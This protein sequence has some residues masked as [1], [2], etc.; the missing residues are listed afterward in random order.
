MVWI[1]FEKCKD[2]RGGLPA[3]TF[4]PSGIES[5]DIEENHSSFQKGLPTDQTQ[6]SNSV[7]TNECSD[8]QSPSSSS[9][10]ADENGNSTLPASAIKQQTILK[11]RHSGYKEDHFK[12][13]VSAENQCLRFAHDDL[14][15]KRRLIDM[16]ERKEKESSDA[17][18]RVTST[19]EKLT[20]SVAAAFD[21]LNTSVLNPQHT[22]P[23]YP[24]YTRL[25]PCSS[26]YHFEH[27]QAM[28]NNTAVGNNGLP[29]GPFSYMHLPLQENI[30]I[31]DTHK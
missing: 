21:V 19:I 7:S 25:Q 29:R 5:A 28:Q 14:Q 11:R 18:E 10:I 27:M 2:I 1:Y 13:K 24:Q 4:I 20:S 16:M 22:Y 23:N 30:D 6:S 8:P 9:S 12:R 15:M 26:N 3:K 31:D 17:M